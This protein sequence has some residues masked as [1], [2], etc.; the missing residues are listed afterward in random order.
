MGISQWMGE[1]YDRIQQHGIK[2]ARHSLRPVKNKIMS[3]SDPLFPPGES[4]YETDW[5]LL[6][7]MDA[8]RLDLMREVAG[9]YD[10][11]DQVESIRSVNS[12]T[13]AWM[14]DTFTENRREQMAETAYI[15]GN[16]F[17]ES[18]LDSRDFSVLKE[19]WQ[20]AWTEPGTVPPEAITD[21]TIQIMREED[22]DHV[23]AHY[24]Q[25][26]CPFLSKPELSRGKDLDKFGDQDWRDVWE[27]L[28]DGDLNPDEVWEG[29]RVN[30]CRGLNE[31]DEL[32]KNVNADRVI[33]TSDHGNAMG[34]WSIYGHPSDLPLRCLRSVPWIETS[35]KDNNTRELEDWQE[36]SVKAD[37]EEQL[38][39]LGY[40]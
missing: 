25:P 6:I 19:V 16:P 28:E 39:A 8:C 7:I 40:R 1:S 18:K 37:R 22:H 11:I 31:V 13:A 15:C 36:N 34:E 20:S 21:E 38:S 10:W 5:D 12:T 17:S 32:L 29:Y 35:A 24:M 3:L 14:R 4:I 23:I 27:Q 30:L 2:G 26:H 9:E 33:V